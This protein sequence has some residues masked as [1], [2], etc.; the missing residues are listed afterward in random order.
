LFS[1]L[2]GYFALQHKGKYNILICAIFFGIMNLLHGV[3][4]PDISSKLTSF[5]SMHVITELYTL[6]LPFSWPFYFFAGMLFR[7]YNLINVIK[8]MKN[9][10]FL[11]WTFLFL[12]YNGLI[13]LNYH[14]I[15][16]CSVIETLYS[17]AIIMVLLLFSPTNKY[18]SLIGQMS[19]TIYLSHLFFVF[20]LRNLSWRIDINWPYWF[21]AVSFMLSLLGPVCLCLFGKKILGDKS[22]LFIGY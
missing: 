17:L 20:G 7:Q 16:Y 6:R 8:E 4:Y 3:Y 14:Y 11:N 22:K 1:Y 15:D 5:A 2:L 18:L 12:I 21:T 19:Y 10:I 13:F 9:S